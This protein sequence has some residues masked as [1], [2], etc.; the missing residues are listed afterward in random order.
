MAIEVSAAEIAPDDVDVLGVPVFAERDVPDNVGVELDL[1]FLETSGFEGKVGETAPLLADDGSTIVA[2]GVGARDKI[3]PDQLRRAAAAFA[4]KASRAGRAAFV[5]P[6]GSGLD[7][8]AFAQA[9]AEGAA[10]ATYRFTRYKSAASASRLES[11]TIVGGSPDAVA[12]GAAVAKAVSLARDLINEP[13]GDMTP[14]RLAD[15]AGEVAS[16]TG[17]E[18][19]V[20]D[21][22][23]IE[24]EGLG[25]LRGVSLG[26]VE[27]PR[28][29]RLTWTPPDSKPAGTVVIVGKGITFDSGGL[30]LKSGD[31]MMTMKTDMSGAAA[32]LATMSALPVT[33]PG[34]RV[35]GIIPA[36]ENMPSGTAIKPGDVLKIRN[37]KT[38]E[39]LNT[40]A[41]GRLV[42]ADGL[43]LA[44]EE[45]PDAIIDLATLTGAVSIALGKEIAGVMGNSQPL[46]D[47][48]IDA[49]NRAGEP[50]WQLPLPQRYRRHLDSE[51][52][53]MKNI[54][55]P[56]QAGTIVAGLF[57]QEFVG[58]VP[59]AHLDI[60]GTARSD[61][62]DGYM[63]KGGTG[64]GVRTL[65]ELLRT[66]ESPAAS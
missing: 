16:R 24:N 10:M 57:L 41:E 29:I 20:M 46:V 17:A 63:T 27:P 11:V 64:A 51:V 49:S 38:A 12:R 61:A 44:A 23:E 59:W 47:Q 3:D 31:G 53:D 25:G 43:S 40:D 58:E 48:V 26:S 37:G 4:R 54:G 18:L 7:Q 8:D 34:V 13:A 1:K 52:A 30:S 60:A 45:E 14:R 65:L 50:M 5:L 36:T 6:A 19:A 9:A 28:L 32:V 62:D 2:V 42:L 35:I 22:T 66:F 21:E 33:Q 39:V 55:N 56:G 15:V